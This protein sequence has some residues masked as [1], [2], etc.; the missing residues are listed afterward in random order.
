[1]L[2]RGK[3]IAAV[4]ALLG[5]SWV[6]YGFPASSQRQLRGLASPYLSPALVSGFPRA[7]VDIL[8]DLMKA[9]GRS[10]ELTPSVRHIYRVHLKAG[11]LLSVTV[12]Q[13][14]IDVRLE[15][16]S[17][18]NRSLFVVDSQNGANGPEPILLVAEKA[19]T[20]QIAVSTGIV[21]PRNGKV[22]DRERR[23]QSGQATGSTQ[24]SSFQGVYQATDSLRKNQ[25]RYSDEIVETFRA[26]ATSLDSS[27]SPR[28]L[29]ADAWFDLG[30]AYAAQSHWQESVK[31][32]AR[33]AELYGTVDNKSRAALALNEEAQGRRIYSRSTYVYSTTKKL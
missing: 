6:T 15:V 9:R 33:S 19:G 31:A 32:Y 25:H 28:N 17:P 27:R 26:A 30:K 11:Q 10:M 23:D 12:Q 7:P 29:R 22:S 18:A 20:Y 21:P 5:A 8:F 13:K 1:M 24:A 2:H 14:E 3:R 4:G 16:F